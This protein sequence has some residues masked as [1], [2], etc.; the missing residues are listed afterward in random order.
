[1]FILFIYFVCVRVFFVIQKGTKI[2]DESH[3]YL[4]IYLFIAQPN[5]QE[6]R[7][8]SVHR[9]GIVKKPHIY[10]W[11]SVIWALNYVNVLLIPTINDNS[12]NC[13]SF[14]SH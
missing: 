13:S 11:F 5:D 14:I 4:F 7:N 8:Y 3:Y 12:C 9:D 1:M 6:T 2:K 10:I